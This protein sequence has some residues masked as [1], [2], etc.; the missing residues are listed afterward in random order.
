MYH[1]THSLYIYGN[2]TGI[3]VDELKAEQRKRSNEGIIKTFKEE[4]NPKH[5][6]NYQTCIN[7]LRLFRRTIRLGRGIQN[8]ISQNTSIVRVFLLQT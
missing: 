1:P 2:L 6:E 5:P 8:Q 3:Y 4:E 7:F